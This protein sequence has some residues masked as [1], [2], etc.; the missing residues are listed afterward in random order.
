MGW[1]IYDM[2]DAMK[3][4]KIVEVV[5]WQNVFQISFI[6][7]TQLFTKLLKTKNKNKI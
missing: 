2:V 5:S 4:L 1:F 7:K 3:Q 6:E